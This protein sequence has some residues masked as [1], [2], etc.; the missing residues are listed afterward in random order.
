[1]EDNNAPANFI[2]NSR[3]VL[4]WTS[5]IIKYFDLC[6]PFLDGPLG[7][8]KT[9]DMKI[10]QDDLSIIERIRVGSDEDKIAIEVKLYEDNYHLVSWDIAKN[11]E[12]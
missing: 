4:F 12:N 5:K 9:L 11:Y 7:Y 2:M 10:D 1:M 3:Y 6:Q 8:L